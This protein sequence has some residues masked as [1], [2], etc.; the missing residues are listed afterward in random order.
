M[1]DD[2]FD[3]NSV[4]QTCECCG[5][6]LRYAWALIETDQGQRFVCILCGLLIRDL[7]KEHSHENT[8]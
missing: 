2:S 6:Q 1:H 4:R 3:Q 7:E 8:Q 5:E